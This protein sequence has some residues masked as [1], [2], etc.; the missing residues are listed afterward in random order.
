MKVGL[1]LP[2]SDPTSLLGWARRAEAGPFSTLGLLDRIVYDTPEP[3]VTLAAIAGIT[4]RIRVQTEVLLAPLR[5]TALL[6]KQAATLDRLSDGRFTLGVGIGAREDDYRAVGVDA[7]SRGRRLNE[8]MATLRRVWAG[9]P[10][11]EDVGPIGPAPARRGGPEML[12]GGSVPA[13]VER[14]ARWGDGFLSTRL[15]PEQMDRFSRTIEESWRAAGRAGHPRLVAQVNAALGPEPI[16]DEARNTLGDYYR[17]FMGDG[18]AKVVDEMLG[19]PEAIRQ[20]VTAYGDA[21]ADEVMLYC[22]SS[23][24][25]QVD[26]VADAIT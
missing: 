5:A 18:A 15:S 10:Y 6:A 12:V 21:G 9:E 3:M 16:L 22:W 11:A 26:R 23:D 1:G 20:A 17:S 14:I 13:T 2:A 25:D 8:Q 4:S 19:T 24:L 7:R